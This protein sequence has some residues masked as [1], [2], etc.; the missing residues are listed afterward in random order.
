[1]GYGNG[2]DAPEIV[3]ATH[4]V[5]VEIGDAV[6]EN[7]TV[8]GTAEDGALADDDLWHGED[9]HEAGM[10]FIHAEFVVMPPSLLHAAE[11]S[12]PLSE[13]FVVSPKLVPELFSSFS[14]SFWRGISEQEKQQ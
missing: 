9:T 11:G 8:G 4:R 12:P 5:I 3:D 6:L 7:I 10:V 1:V 13:K 14:P 2:I